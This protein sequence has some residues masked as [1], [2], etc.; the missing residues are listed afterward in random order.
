MREEAEIGMV[1]DVELKGRGRGVRELGASRRRKR[2]RTDLV[3][4]ST[5]VKDCRSDAKA[6]VEVDGGAFQARKAG[7]M[8][9]GRGEG[10]KGELDFFRRFYPSKPDRCSRFP[11]KP[12]L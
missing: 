11:D 6:D 7:W 8:G 1:V 3:P 2:S 4:G 10:R 5:H 9:G 12:F